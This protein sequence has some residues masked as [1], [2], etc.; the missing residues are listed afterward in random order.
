MRRRLLT[1]LA[2]VALGAGTVQQAGAAL[3]K[4]DRKVLNRAPEV[5]T[6][7]TGAPDDRIPDEL[8]ERAECVL[9]F[10][11]VTKAAFVVGG[12]Y[13]RGV[14]SCRSAPGSPLGAP[15]FFKVGGG[16]VGWQ[17][18]GNQTDLVL[19][20]MNDTGMRHLLKDKFSLGGEVTAAAGPV[21]RTAQAATDITLRAQILSWSRSRGLF[22]GASLEGASIFADKD[23]NARLYGAGVLPRDILLE[24]QRPIPDAA[25]PFV[26]LARKL[27]SSQP[28]VARKG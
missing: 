28:T 27:T 15:A 11:D 5:L 16:S 8:M 14:A 19:L 21:G 3:D 23:A 20:V 9:V 26:N 18:G 7:L 1:L 2:V 17:I 6:A 13:G 22:V 4:K 24:G 25:R 12:K 10:P